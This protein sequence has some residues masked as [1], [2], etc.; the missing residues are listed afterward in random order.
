VAFVYILVAIKMATESS[1][2]FEAEIVNATFPSVAVTPLSFTD[3]LT[4]LRAQRVCVQDGKDFIISG[5]NPDGY[6]WQV[7]LIKCDSRKCDE[8]NVGT[9][10]RPF[11][12]YAIVAVAGSD[13]GGKARANDFKAWM[14]ATYPAIVSEMP[15]DFSLVQVFDSSTAMNDYI[16]RPQYGE[17]T[18]PKIGMGIVWE[19]NDN[20][21]FSYHLRPNATNFNAPEQ[22]ARPATITTPSTGLVTDSFARDD[23]SVCI[24]MD[25]SSTQGPLEQSCTGQ[26]LYNGVLTFQRVVN[27]FVLDQSGAAALGYKVAEAGVQ[28]INFPTKEYESAGFYATIAGTSLSASGQRQCHSTRFLSFFSFS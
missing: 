5:Y 3:Y 21:K 15:F 20:A 24:P 10:A 23:F 2:T 9:D 16:R 19:G 1:G 11:C 8:T 25:G 4:A 13:E 26:Y 28:F 7:P 12:E 17:V 18:K 6:N 27:D 22:E 14:E